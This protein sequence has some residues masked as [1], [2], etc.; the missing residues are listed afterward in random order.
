MAPPSVDRWGPGTRV[1]ALIISP[2]ARQGYVDHTSYDTT[3]ILA[4]IEHRWGLAPLSARDAQAA[5]SAAAFDF[6]ATP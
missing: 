4:L 5:D 3:S 1:P 2:F 6:S